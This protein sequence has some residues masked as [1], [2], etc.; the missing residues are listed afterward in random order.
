MNILTTTAFSIQNRL[1]SAIAGAGAFALGV[2][3]ALFAW[4]FVVRFGT[5]DITSFSA[6]VGVLAGGVVVT[7]IDKLRGGTASGLALYCIGLLVGSLFFIY[8]GNLGPDQA[9]WMPKS[10]PTLKPSPTS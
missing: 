9:K 5:F 10:T 4:Y 8:L 1:N 7:F 6:L 3:I 2:V